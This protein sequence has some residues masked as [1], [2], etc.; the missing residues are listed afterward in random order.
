LG[1]DLDIS[2]GGLISIYVNM[3]EHE[4]EL[5]KEVAHLELRRDNNVWHHYL[6]GRRVKSG[7]ELELRLSGDRWLRGRYEWNGNAVVWPAFRILLEGKVSQTSERKLTGALPL[8]PNAWLRW[9]A[10]R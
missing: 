2:I 9:P 7:D 10:P 8:P 6:L 3:L 5:E 4:H 1:C